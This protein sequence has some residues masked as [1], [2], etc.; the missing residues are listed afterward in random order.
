VTGP[1]QDFREIVVSHSAEFSRNT[2]IVENPI[3]QRVFTNSCSEPEYQTSGAPGQDPYL[4]GQTHRRGTLWPGDSG[5]L[6]ALSFSPIPPLNLAVPGLHP[7]LP[8]VVWHT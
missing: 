4:L 7:G 2:L 5:R 3:F 6:V 8:I 1:P